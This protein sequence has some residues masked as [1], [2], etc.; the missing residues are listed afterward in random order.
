MRNRNHDIMGAALGFPNVGN[1]FPGAWGPGYGGPWGGYPTTAFGLVLDTSQQMQ[2]PSGPMMAPPC[3][4]PPSYADQNL[5]NAM[6]L[7]Q[8][9]AIVGA[10]CGPQ[11][12]EQMFGN[13]A[14]DDLEPQA[15]VNLEF[16]PELVCKLTRLFI[17]TSIASQLVVLDLSIGIKSQFPGKGVQPALVYSEVSTNNRINGDTCYIRQPI[18]LTIKNIS[19][20]TIPGDLLACAVGVV[21]V[22]GA[23]PRIYGPGSGHQ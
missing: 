7:K 23:G 8:H 14:A 13:A 9:S 21:A 6:I 19:G 10:D 2:A 17:P 12:T 18:V 16:T 5:V 20:N 15:S 11:E 4:Y 22:Q 1:G 3:G